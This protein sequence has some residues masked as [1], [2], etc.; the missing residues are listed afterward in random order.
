MPDYRKLL[1][2]LRDSYNS[3]DPDRW[4]EVWNPDSEWHPF[5]TAREEGDPGYHGHNGMRTWFEDLDELFELTHVELERFRSI[6][7]RLLVLGRMTARRRGS[8]EEVESDVGWVVEP[9]GER[10]QRGWAYD[11]HEEAERAA[12]A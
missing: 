12:K 4:V 7:D 8:A 5:T 10:F 9:K 3:R 11:S 6:G 2:Q 1:E